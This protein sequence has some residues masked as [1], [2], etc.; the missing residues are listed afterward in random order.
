VIDELD[1]YGELHRFIPALVS[2]AGF[3][4]TEIKVNHRM[5]ICGRS[6]YGFKRFFEGFFDLITVIF[7][8]RFTKKPMHFFGNFGLFSSLLGLLIIV[9]LYIRKFIFGIIISHNP[10]LFFLGILLILVGFQFFSVGLLGELILRFNSENI[11]KSYVR[12][13]LHS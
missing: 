13:I 11:K 9:F 3:R 1:I 2:S 8:T 4:I 7:L 6:K 10:Y 5:R 12:E